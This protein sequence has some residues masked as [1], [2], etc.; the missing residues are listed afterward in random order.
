MGAAS[1]ETR[2]L[3]AVV[4]ME[5]ARAEVEAREIMAGALQMRTIGLAGTGAVATM[6]HGATAADVVK[7][8]DVAVMEEDLQMI[9][10]GL[11]IPATAVHVIAGL[12]AGH[13][14]ITMTAAAAAAGNHYRYLQMK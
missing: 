3:T 4:V 5:A 8:V 6:V 13:N 14:G 7:T 11:A 9:T 10:T 1:T 12:A 2:V